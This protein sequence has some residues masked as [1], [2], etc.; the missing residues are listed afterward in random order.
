MKEF[1]NCSKTISNHCVGLDSDASVLLSSLKN[2]SKSSNEQLASLRSHVDNFSDTQAALI[3][4][5]STYIDSQISK[6]QES[7]QT[8]LSRENDSSEC[9]SLIQGA[10]QDI[11]KRLSGEYAEWAVSFTRSIDELCV[12]TE[13]SSSAQHDA[14]SARLANTVSCY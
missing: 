12:E 2:L 5:Q 6:L 10:L 9:I 1:D 11:Q 7:L 3:A 4:E 14:V 13:R 8:V